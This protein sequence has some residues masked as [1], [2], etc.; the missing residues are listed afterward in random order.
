MITQTTAEQT[1]NMIDI[2]IHQMIIVTGITQPVQHTATGHHTANM[3]AVTTQLT[4][5]AITAATIRHTATNQ[6]RQP[7]NTTHS[8]QPMTLTTTHC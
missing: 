2:M 7:V 6:V 5:S 4:H 3:T 1:T 8:S